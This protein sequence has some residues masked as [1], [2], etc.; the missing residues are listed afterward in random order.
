MKDLIRSIALDEQAELENF[1]SLEKFAEICSVTVYNIREGRDPT[2][3]GCGT[4]RKRYI[5]FSSMRRG[6]IQ[7]R[8]G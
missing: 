2:D 5:G 7:D 3:E 4:Y 1:R 8:D 6:A